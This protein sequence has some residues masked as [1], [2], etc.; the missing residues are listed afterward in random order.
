MKIVLRII[1]ITFIFSIISFSS[2]LHAKP[3]ST[4]KG[5]VVSK[6]GEPLSYANI[7]IQDRYE[8]AIT[9]NNGKFL[10]KVSKVGKMN[11]ICS[12]IGYSTFKKE[13]FVK[14]N[15]IVNLDIILTPTEIKGKSVYVTASAFSAADEEGVTLTSL[16]VV[17]TPG[18]AAD[19][20]W[21]IKTFPGLQQV[22]EGAGL[23]VRGGDVSETI[24]IL[25][26]AVI[27][28]PYKHESPTG[29]FFGTFSPFLL[30]GTFFSSGGF[31]AQYGNALSGALSMESHD[32]PLQRKIGF[33]LGLAAESAYISVPLIEDKFGVAFSG[34]KSNT[35]MLFDLNNTSNNFS[36]YPSSYDINLSAIYKINNENSVKFFIFQEDDKVGIQVDDPVYESHFHG[37]T[38][39]RLYN[40]VY[41]GLI[42]NKWL[43]QANCAVSEFG[44]DMQL[45][46]M[47]LETNDKLYQGRITIETN[48][49][50]NSTLRAG[51]V[52]FRNKTIF[53]GKVPMENSDINPEAECKKVA[54]DYLSNRAAQFIEYEFP[55][56]FGF[57]LT[58]GI[59]S[60]YE[61]ISN[62]YFID[63]RIS[64][65]YPL[66][67]YTNITAAWGIYHQY[68]Q[69]RYYDSYIGNPKLSSMRAVHYILGYA[70]KK[71]N[72]IFRIEGY[73]KDYKHLLLEQDSPINYTNDGR[74]FAGGVDVFIKN[75]Y[76][77]LSGW[78]SY[79]WLKAR[80]K[81]MDIPV[82][83][84]PYFDISNNLSL[85]LTIDLPMRFTL[86]SSFRYATG[87]P[88]TPY[89]ERYNESRVPDYQKW[90]LTLTKLFS[91]FNNNLTV[92]YM[93]FSNVLG[94]INVFDYRYSEDYSKRA[95]VESSFGR[96]IYFG[97]S[98]NM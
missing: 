50:D 84:S 86:G 98:F 10:F 55:T 70:Y 73:F 28:H 75:S 44:R 66:T 82:L 12:F 93:S 53:T 19:I 41:K 25:D 60:E 71:D 46:V 9:D 97:V 47:N 80:R 94:R 43:V 2:L 15:S 48:L 63:P 27:S 39:N 14:K 83:T 77:P 34:N 69:P 78:I 90:D 3:N 7:F 29:G 22:E 18:A 33:G 21:A 95:P 54:T 37:T 35:K 88:Y 31:S 57:I 1:L 52:F 30:K 24:T 81:W 62:E 79:S 58:P 91:F 20:F 64:L 59:R 26:G 74:G 42:K 16:D 40:L 6:K 68:P 11:L 17:R 38:S 36:H 23:F 4:I 49:N 56:S 5:R 65:N 92:F 8:G 32:L 45:G 72:K 89:F 76:G 13:I 96:S 67:T 51:T 87:K 61:S 85:V